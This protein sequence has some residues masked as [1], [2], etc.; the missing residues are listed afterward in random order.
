MGQTGFPLIFTGAGGRVGRL[1]RGVMPA[2]RVTWVSREP[3]MLDDVAWDDL[4]A[5]APAGAVILHFAGA[6][7]GNL[8]LNTLLARQ[9]CG[10]Q[11]VR[12]VFV[13]SSAAVYPPGD[14][15]LDEN[16][17]PDAQSAYGAA[18]LAMEQAVQRPGVTL[19]RIGNVAGAD[20]LLG[21]LVAGGRCV[22]DP[23]AGQEGG[24]HRS[25]IGPI[26][27][28]RVLLGVAD[29]AH[30]GAVLP[31]VLNVAA[32]GAVSM[33]DLLDAAG[34]DWAYGA[35]KASV[36]PRVVLDVQRLCGLVPVA[37][38]TAAALVDEWR[39]AQ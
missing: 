16:T 20:A 13:A 6:V 33:A 35:E 23:V 18:K 30:A 29:M 24:P 4:L 37:T 34:A 8:G 26:T 14:A 9:V 28:A 3:A 31:Q 10:L 36:V 19:L 11:G 22:L 32:P 12:H 27:L 1:L 21:G 5:G 2:G 38:A 25:Y 17:L 39:R 15:D 7:Q